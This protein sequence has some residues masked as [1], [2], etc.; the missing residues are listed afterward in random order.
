MEKLMELQTTVT[1]SKGE[2]KTQATGSRLATTPVQT[3]G[4]SKFT[5]SFDGDDHVVVYGYFSDGSQQLLLD[6]YI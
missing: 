5:G 3:G 1:D 4:T 6:T 2:S